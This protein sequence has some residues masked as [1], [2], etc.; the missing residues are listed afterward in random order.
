MRIK[1]EMITIL[2]MVESALALSDIENKERGE[3]LQMM[4]TAY[5]AG[6][7]EGIA[8]SAEEALDILDS[9]RTNCAIVCMAMGELPDVVEQSLVT[10]DE[11]EDRLSRKLND[12]PI[13]PEELN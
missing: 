13:M 11:F 10:L 9:M 4:L 1:K 3:I 7:A 12:I 6:F 2:Q 5:K 8:V